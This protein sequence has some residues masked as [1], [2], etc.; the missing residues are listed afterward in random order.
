VLVVTDSFFE[1]LGIYLAHISWLLRRSP[2]GR[3]VDRLLM[4]I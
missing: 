2:A 3:G 1:G 4:F